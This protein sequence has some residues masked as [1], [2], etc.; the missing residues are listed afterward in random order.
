MT[1]THPWGTFFLLDT[2]AILVSYKKGAMVR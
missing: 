2:L 1:R